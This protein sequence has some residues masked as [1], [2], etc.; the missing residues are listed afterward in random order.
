MTN[1]KAIAYESV[2][3]AED[4][5]DNDYSETR[6]RIVDTETGEILDDAQG[7]G[8]KSAKKAYAAWSYKNRTP[9]QKAKEK[10]DKEMVR[11]WCKENKEIVNTLSQFA[12]EITM[13]KWAPDDKFD[14][15]FV[16]NFMK[17]S[18]IELPFSAKTLLK[19][20]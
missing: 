4:M 13:G 19:Y 3:R 2:H 18:D 9:Q 10:S 20:W 11:K 15:K 17:E 5:Y 7:Y 6:Y 12:L 14:E 8:Y 16:E 1:I